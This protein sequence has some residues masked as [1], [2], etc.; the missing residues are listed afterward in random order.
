MDEDDE[1]EAALDAVLQAEMGEAAPLDD[2]LPCG[3]E[4]EDDEDED[5]DGGIFTQTTS[6]GK[7]SG[8]FIKEGDLPPVKPPPDNF[9]R[10]GSSKTKDLKPWPLF[11]STQGTDCEVKAGQMLF[12]PAG[13]FHDVTSMSGETDDSQS[14]PTTRFHMAFNYW[15]HPPAPAG[16]ES[17]SKPYDSDFWKTEWD[18]RRLGKKV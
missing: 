13:W 15:F 9:S 12:L 2:T 7:T 10:I 3:G 17:F 11:R 14:V 8:N 4:T 18:S 6:D 1:I 16:G 5:G